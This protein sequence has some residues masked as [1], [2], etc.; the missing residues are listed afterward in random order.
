MG[1]APGKFSSVPTARMRK[2][3]RYP[4]DNETESNGSDPEALDEEEQEHL[5]NRLAEENAS[6]NAFFARVL[7]CLPIA[8]CLPYLPTLFHAK[9]R[10]LSVLSITSLLSTAFLLWRYPTTQTGIEILDKLHTKGKPKAKVLD[11]S[12]L[13][14]WLPYLNLGLA[15]MLV[16]MGLLVKSDATS[17]GWISMGNL[18]VIIYAVALVCKVVMASV[19]PESELS[20]L[21]YEYKGA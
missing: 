3:F 15:V 12:P 5:I 9:M 14:T 11:R 2:T 6:R 10:M 1:G 21:K 16:L 20:S 19:D 4:A 13:E 7:L 18:P 17:F 8:A